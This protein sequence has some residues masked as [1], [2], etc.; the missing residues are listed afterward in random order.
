VEVQVKQWTGTR[1][2][3]YGRETWRLAVPLP[4]ATLKSIARAKMSLLTWVVWND[5]VIDVLT[6][7]GK[8]SLI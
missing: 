1:W 6:E 5:E 8:R 3:E 7:D 2:W 4:E